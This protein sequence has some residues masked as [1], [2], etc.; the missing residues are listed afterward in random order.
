MDLI[1][2]IFKCACNFLVLDTIDWSSPEYIT[3]IHFLSYDH[4]PN[5]HWCIYNFRNCLLCVVIV[6]L[7]C[8][9]QCIYPKLEISSNSY[10]MS[11]YGF[12]TLFFSPALILVYL[13]NLLWIQCYW[14]SVIDMFANVTT[15]FLTPMEL[16]W[17][18][19]EIV[20]YSLNDY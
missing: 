20:F 2:E 4:I 9:M 3:F 14:Y 1:I 12:W 10:F 13:Y 7:T 16:L 8:D 17:R 18:W 15:F 6:Y 5:L 19:S 11:N